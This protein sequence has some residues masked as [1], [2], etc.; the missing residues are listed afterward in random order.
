MSEFA[1][2]ADR[3]ADVRNGWIDEAGRALQILTG[4]RGRARII[5]S[6]SR[7]EQLQIRPPRRAERLSGART[8]IVLF[9]DGTVA[10]RPFAGLRREGDI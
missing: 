2:A 7:L 9:D 8:V 6:S 3:T 1:V 5:A 4:W 10:I